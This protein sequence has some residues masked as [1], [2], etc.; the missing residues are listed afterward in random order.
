[1]NKTIQDMLTKDEQVRLRC[2]DAEC[3][4]SSAYESFI[5]NLD[6]SAKV[7]RVLRELARKTVDLGGRVVR[8]GKIALDFTIKVLSELHRRFPNVTYG[9]LVLLILKVLISSIP[10]LGPIFAALLEPLFMVALVGVGVG[11]DLYERVIG[12]IAARHFNVSSA[13]AR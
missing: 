13:M 9:I 2:L 8:V 12:P 6:C 5:D 10:F 4:E 11:L 3:R 7:K 1:M